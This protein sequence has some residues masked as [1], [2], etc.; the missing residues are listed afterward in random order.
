MFRAILFRD[1]KQMIS[2][3]GIIICLSLYMVIGCGVELA[4]VAISRYS[5]F[6]MF[7]LCAV[8]SFGITGGLTELIKYDKNSGIFSLLHQID[9]GFAKY[10]FA[11][12]ILPIILM[13]IECAV[14]WVIYIPYGL[15][16]G[17][18]FQDIVLSVIVAECMTVSLIS[19]SL[20]VI[21]WSGGKLLP[22]LAVAE[23][24][25]LTMFVVIAVFSVFAAVALTLVFACGV[26][27]S[28]ALYVHSHYVCVLK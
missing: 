17:L 1:C 4:A 26:L 14:M 9:G 5:V 7:Y 22:V 21:S 10:Y 8:W 15:Q 28:L 19:L 6:L 27:V 12:M 2:S 18:R 13:A 20:L 24:V 3:V 11:K 25:V 23:L 16:N